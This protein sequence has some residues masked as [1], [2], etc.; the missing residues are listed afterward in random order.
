MKMKLSGEQF[1]RASVRLVAA[2]LLVT[3]LAMGP[4]I[5]LAAERD[6]REDRVELR[7]HDMHAKLKITAAQEAQGVKVALAMREVGKVMDA[8]NGWRP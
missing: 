8:Q 2:A 7:I 5:L 4:G 1:D 6:A 3:T